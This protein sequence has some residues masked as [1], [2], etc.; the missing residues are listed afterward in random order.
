MKKLR[1]FVFI[2]CILTMS[3]LSSCN[4][5]SLNSEVNDMKGQLIGNSFECQ[6][7]DNYGEK[8][9]TASGTKIGMT[10]NIVKESKINSSDGT[11]ATEY[12]L[13]SVVTIN[14][15]GKQ[16]QSC[17]DT[18]IFEESSL[19]PDAEFQLSDIESGSSDGFSENTIISGI[20]ND[21]KNFFGKGQVVVIQ[22]QLGVPICAYSGDDVYWEV[23][24]DLP[25]TT[26]LMIDGKALY[27]HRA[28]FQIIDKDLIY[29]AFYK[30]QPIGFFLMFPELNQVVK[31]LNGKMNLF[32]KLKFMYYLKARKIDVALGQLFGVVPEFQGK[33]V[34]A[35][36]IKRF[37]ECI[38]EKGRE[39][40]Y[41]ELNWVGDF[42]PPM[43]HLMDY[44]GAKVVRTYVTYRKLF[45]DDIEFVRSADKMQNID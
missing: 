9:L 17:G 37:T 19:K 15:D 16:I 29:F 4:I 18:I 11:T 44:I 1:N 23:R 13:S 5:A 35:A 25:K 38:I 10:G 32:G 26:K 12:A 34:E 14:I 40:K 21:Y 6:F 41:L 31:H 33:G 30:G 27:I 28:N 22:S 2:I 3:L 24:N 8:F 36:M 39:Y 7:Y 42:N 20:V 43:I 45:R